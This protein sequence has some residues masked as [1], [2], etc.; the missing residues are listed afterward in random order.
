M[1]CDLKL[2]GYSELYAAGIADHFTRRQEYTPE[3]YYGLIDPSD[4]EAMNAH[5]RAI[6][7]DYNE[8]NNE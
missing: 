5:M 7:Y 1:A 4:D 2:A 3:E 6:R 8:F